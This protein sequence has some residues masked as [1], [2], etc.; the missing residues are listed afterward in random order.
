MKNGKCFSGRSRAQEAREAAG[1][2]RRVRACR[3]RRG[4]DEGREPRREPGDALGR[5]PKRD[6]NNLL[7]L[8]QF[9]SPFFLARVAP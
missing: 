4:G 5:D 2:R 7:F 6:L 3:P 8:R 1:G 9:F